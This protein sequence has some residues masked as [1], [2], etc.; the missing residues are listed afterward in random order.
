ML[1]A[2]SRAPRIFLDSFE[3]ILYNGYMPLLINRFKLLKENMCKAREVVGYA[4][5]CAS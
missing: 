1:A 3:F 5:L 4:D 2:I